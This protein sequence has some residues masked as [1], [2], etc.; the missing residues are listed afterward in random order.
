MIHFF[1]LQRHEQILC[2]H[3]L[4][5]CTLLNICGKGHKDGERWFYAGT[6]ERKLMVTLLTRVL[7][8]YSLWSVKLFLQTGHAREKETSPLIGNGLIPIHMHTAGID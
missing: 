3:D 1:Y 5:G 4:L 2:R 6:K 8:C 7:Q